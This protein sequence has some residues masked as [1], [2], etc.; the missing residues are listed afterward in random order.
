MQT[1]TPY[2]YYADVDAA[3]SFLAEAFGF[4]ETL[5]YTGAEGYVSHAEMRVG[6][7]AIMMGDPGES[8]RSPAQLGGST[9]GTHVYV[10]DVD[11]AFEQARAAGA[12]IREE[13]TDKP[14]GDRSF[15]A[16][17]PE[18]HEWFIATHVRDVPLEEWGGA[19]S[20]E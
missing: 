19:V 14:Y 18:G 3:L 5:R 11:A 10:D 9:Q 12:E 4:E 13:P 7:A 8:F 15:T 17:D 6:D 16:R 2:L 1:V 20:G